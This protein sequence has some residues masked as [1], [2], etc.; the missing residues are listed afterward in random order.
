MYHISRFWFLYEAL[1]TALP[2]PC[3]ALGVVPATDAGLDVLPATGAVFADADSAEDAFCICICTALCNDVARTPPCNDVEAEAALDDILAGVKGSTF[4]IA[5]GCEVPNGHQK[6][7][8]HHPENIGISSKGAISL[9][10]AVLVFS[11]LLH[12]RHLHKRTPNGVDVCVLFLIP[13]SFL[14]MAFALPLQGSLA[15]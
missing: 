7:H 4:A 6:I 8:N 11:N 3:C 13:T 14:W 9:I 5:D 2:C 1:A 10:G 12:R 15:A